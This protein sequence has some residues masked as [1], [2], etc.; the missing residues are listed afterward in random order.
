MLHVLTNINNFQN[1]SENSFE[2]KEESNSSLSYLGKLMLYS[3]RN[4]LK[5]NSSSEEEK[6]L[7]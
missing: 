5:Q 7:D 2:K 3:N 6:T 4:V 1:Y